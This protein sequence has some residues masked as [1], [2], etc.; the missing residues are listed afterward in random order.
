VSPRTIRRIVFV[1]FLAGV[2]GMIVGSIEDNNGFAITFGVISAFAALT[3]IIVTSVAPPE[4]WAGHRRSRPAGSSLPADIAVFDEVVAA[5]VERR[6][7][8]L[9]EGGADEADLRRLVRRAIELG[10]GPR[11]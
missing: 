10:R 9:V 6:I 2:A 1:V 11:R 8:A 5:D 7:V 3:L 4:S